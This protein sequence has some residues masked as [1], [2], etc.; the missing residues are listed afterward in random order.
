MA[1]DPEH[2]DA[3]SRLRFFKKRAKVQPEQPETVASEP[4]IEA[5]DTAAAADAQAGSPEV[6]Q[7]ESLQPEIK[8]AK[9]KSAKTSRSKLGA[10]FAPA[11][12]LTV[13]ALVI[14]AVLSAG[15]IAATLLVTQVIGPMMADARLADT[16]RQLEQITLA[17]NP[18]TGSKTPAAGGATME[19]RAGGAHK[20]KPKKAESSG[21]S[22]WTNISDL[23]VNPAETD[24][25]RYVCATVALESRS[26]KVAEE[27]KARESQIR[28]SLIKIL[29]KRTV[30]E[31]S[32]LAVREHIREEIKQ[33]VND[34]LPIGRVEGV[35]FANFVLQ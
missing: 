10:V 34:L 26:P 15:A 4:V 28:D 17:Q 35:Y 2:G 30:T 9:R 33:E 12:A 1:R 31:L 22:V 7:Q 6:S 14:L 32:S 21:E 19:S 5:A 18:Q 3:K 11:I 16:Q 23:V 8:S 13:R 20:E 25:T 29:G 27:I 24:G